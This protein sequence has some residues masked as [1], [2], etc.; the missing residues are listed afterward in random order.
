MTPKDTERFPT[1]EAF[2]EH[3]VGMRLAAH[4]FARDYGM[5]NY[6]C[7]HADNSH[8]SG[9]R[10]ALDRVWNDDH[11]APLIPWLLYFR[12]GDPKHF[13]FARR[14]SRHLMNVDVT[15][16]VT[17]GYATSV[18]VAVEGVR[19]IRTTAESHRRI[20]IVEVMGRNAGYIALGCA[21]GQPDIALIP[22]CPLDVDRLV[23][24]VRELYDLQKN[25]VIVCG[26][27]ITDK[28]GVE[29]GAQQ[30]TYDPAGNVQLTGASEAIRDVLLQYFSDDYF[31]AS[32]RA[33]SAP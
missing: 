10:W 19:R 17:P 18:Y 8:F 28:N 2:M 24:R 23:H 12:S 14:N 31:Q 25:V 20:A 26:E 5:F 22:E 27:G 21:Y 6:Q 33:E 16:Y 9:G 1:A 15:H 11:G 3:A 4:D 7:I 30:P 29:L 13:Q 32:R